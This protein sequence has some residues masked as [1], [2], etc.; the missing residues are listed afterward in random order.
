VATFFISYSR[1]DGAAIANQL[2]NH[3]TK[4]DSSHDVFLDI[5]SIAAGSNWKA[6]L[7]RKIIAADYFIYI[8]S[9]NSFLSANVKEELKWV[10]ES[11]LRSGM[12]KLFVYRLGYAELTA[13]IASYQILDA[14]ENFA[15]DFYK[16]MAGIFSE[17]SF[18]SV[19]YDIEL[20]D[21]FWYK[22]KIWI[23]APAKFLSKIQMVEYRFDYGW[24]ENALCI[25]KGNVANCAKKFE[26][27]FTTKYHFT[28]FVMLYLWNTKELAF[29]KKIHISH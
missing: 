18:Y 17:H 25:V 22:G 26:K 12:R 29:V 8:H 27:K 5:H 1:K 9:P 10:K 2:R 11:E 24:D 7:K 21:E 15:V 6:E 20:V 16:L 3:I 28:L 19:A 13:D 14:T 23:E 4:L